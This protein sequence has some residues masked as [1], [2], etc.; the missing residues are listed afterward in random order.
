MIGLDGASGLMAMLAGVAATL[1]FML[2][3]ADKGRTR[4]LFLW[5]AFSAIFIHFNIELVA[6]AILNAKAITGH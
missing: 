4:F 1:F 5:A 3:I 6:A 2:A